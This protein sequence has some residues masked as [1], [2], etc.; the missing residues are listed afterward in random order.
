MQ[1]HKPVLLLQAATLHS[2]GNI[3]LRLIPSH[4][5]V[6]CRAGAAVFMKVQDLVFYI[7]GS[8]EYDELM[9]A[10]LWLSLS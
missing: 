2:P 7:I 3:A 1:A 4:V 5:S 8:G 9:R 10:S 6:I